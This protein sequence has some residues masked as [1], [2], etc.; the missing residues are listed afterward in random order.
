MSNKSAIQTRSL[1]QTLRLVGSSE[2]FTKR[3]ILWTLPIGLF[4]AAGYDANRFETSRLGWL[5]V[6]LVAHAGAALVMLIL[7]LLF[8]PSGPYEPL[9]LRTLSIFGLGSISRSM[10][11][12]ELSFSMNLAPETEIGYRI[13]AGALLGTLTLSAVAL[14]AAVTKY[15]ADTQMELF[16]ERESLLIAQETA[17]QLVEEQRAEVAGIVRQSIEPSLQ[18]IS[19]NL[20]DSNIQDSAKLKNSASAISTFIDSTLRPLSSSLHKKQEIQIPRVTSIGEKPSLIS[21]PKFIVLR[22]V[23]S[24]IA[25]YFVQV[26][27]NVTG[28][29]PY[30][31]YK[32]LPYVLVMYAPM[33]VLQ[34]LFLR[35]PVA[36]KRL[37]SRIAMVIAALLFAVSWTPVIPFARYFGLDVIDELGFIPVLTLGNIMVG[38]LLTYG[39]IV[40]NQRMAY[41]ADL[42]LANQELNRELN[43][44]AQEI[45]HVRQHAAQ[46]LHGSV[47]ASLTA[48]N[49]RILGATEVTEELL[50]KVREDVIR[51][52]DS[53]SSLGSINVD[54]QD[55]LNELVEL[56]RGMCEITIMP[57]HELISNLSTNQVTAHCV[58]EIVKE[59]VNNAIRHGHAERVEVNIEDLN[60]GSLR[61]TVANDGDANIYGE[62]G[63]G[64]QILDEITMEWSRELSGSR[65]I[66]TA[67]VASGSIAKTLDL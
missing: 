19:R 4:V 17:E 45:W 54:L 57:N 51:A 42:R 48:A 14:V 66:V 5:V 24:P 40:D 38:L 56:W 47:Q 60:D 21:L 50:G 67:Q 53:L 30:A 55:S 33:F 29:F 62:E 26:V 63:V 43:R 61:V 31:G 58:N 27:P 46:V 41:E 35:L 13:L 1:E 20:N 2:A 8:I 9:P 44:T 16:I 15:H 34:T 28:T 64:S 59:C 65:V 37:R 10:I 3:V 49:M 11:V 23:V 25:I 36:G 6:G 18:E 32:A 39:F 12:A 22:D 52:T 7:R